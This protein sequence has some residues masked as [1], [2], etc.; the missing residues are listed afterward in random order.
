M[1]AAAEVVAYRIATEAVTNSARRSGTDQAWVQIEYEADLL[2]VTVSDAGSAHEP[3]ATAQRSFDLGI[4]DQVTARPVPGQRGGASADSSS[5]SAAQVAQS[6]FAAVTRTPFC[7]ARR[8]NRS[9]PLWSHAVSRST[10]SST[11]WNCR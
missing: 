7:S 8:A 6:T 9:N 4:L 11:S 10:A 3:L 2:K 5:W 1:P